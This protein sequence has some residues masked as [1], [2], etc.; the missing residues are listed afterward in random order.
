MK[1]EWNTAG[2]G[3]DKHIYA[4]PREDVLVEVRKEGGP[5]GAFI[6]VDIDDD[7]GW[8]GTDSRQK[9]FATQDQAKAGCEEFLGKESG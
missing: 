2:L 9:E 8:I 1:F 3:R 6:E 7:R 5:F 4:R